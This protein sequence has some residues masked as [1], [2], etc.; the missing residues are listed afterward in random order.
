MI[1]ISHGTCDVCLHERKLGE[2]IKPSTVVLNINHKQIEFCDEHFTEFKD[3]FDKYYKE[4]FLQG[5]V[6]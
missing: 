2:K 4:K 3:S 6:E 1:N 5:E